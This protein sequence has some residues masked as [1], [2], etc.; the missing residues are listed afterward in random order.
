MRNPA[1]RKHSLQPC[2]P[3]GRRIRFALGDLHKARAK[4][5]GQRQHGQH[6]QRQKPGNLPAQRLRKQPQQPRGARIE[7]ASRPTDAQTTTQIED[8][9]A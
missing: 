3:S 7:L 1:F 4:L 6:R 8:A 2:P 5:P 9:T